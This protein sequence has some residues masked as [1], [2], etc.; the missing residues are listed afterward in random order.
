MGIPHLSTPVPAIPAPPEPSGIPSEQMDRE[1]IVHVGDALTTR[2]PGLYMHGA[3]VG[4]TP[5][6]GS[7]AILSLRGQSQ[8]RVKVLLDGLPVNDAST[9]VAHGLSGI[10]NGDI[11]RIEVVPG[12]GS[13]LYGSDAIG[14]VINILSR[15][16]QKRE[17]SGRFVQGFNENRKTVAELILRDR[18]SNSIGY[19]VGI[20]REVFQGFDRSD[21]VAATVGG[22]GTGELAAAGGVPTTTS[23]G[24]PAYI[25]G[26]KG[27]TRSSLTNITAKLFANLNPT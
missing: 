18:F 19:T 21:M 1:N 5:R 3:F 4:S 6:L 22:T 23:R 13:A 9:S 20:D 24:L 17:V 27:A 7:S 26:H 10:L 25:I 16:P 2:V 12:V 14:G 15:G 11:D 8:S